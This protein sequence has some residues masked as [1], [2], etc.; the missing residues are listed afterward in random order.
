MR[1]II[2]VAVVSLAAATAICCSSRAE[3]TATELTDADAAR[4]VGD[5]LNQQSNETV[6]LGNIVVYANTAPIPPGNN[7]RSSQYLRYK[8][9]ESIGV[10]DIV[11]KSGSSPGPFPWADWHSTTGKILDRIIVSPTSK[12]TGYGFYLGT[13]LTIT[14]AISKV[15]DLIK[16]EERVIGVHT[17]RILM[18]TYVS[19]WTPAFLNF[20][21]ASNACAS[22]Q[23]GKFIVLVK[24]NDFTQR[25]NVV[26]WDVADFDHEFTTRNVDQQLISLR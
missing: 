1:I 26:A 16:N 4:I 14:L 5:L 2:A 19:S 22:A 13:T 9:W 21:R 15:D 8:V 25:W 6:L 18:G 20:C 7:I 17:Y 3:P 12:A 11:T 24:L 10:I 23:K